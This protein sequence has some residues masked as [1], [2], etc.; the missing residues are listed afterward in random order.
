MLRNA[1]HSP[2]LRCKAQDAAKDSLGTPEGARNSSVPL[3]TS[4]GG[5]Q[6]PKSMADLACETSPREQQQMHLDSAVLYCTFIHATSII[7]SSWCIIR[8]INRDLFYLSYDNMHVS[9]D[10]SVVCV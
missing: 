4:P 6:H 8:S 7:I 5:D 10:L 9:I 1:T 3:A 2:L